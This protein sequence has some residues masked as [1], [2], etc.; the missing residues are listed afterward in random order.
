MHGFNAEVVVRDPDRPVS[1][2]AVLRASAAVDELVEAIVRRWTHQ[3][4]LLHSVFVLCFL[5]RVVGLGIGVFL[6]ALLFLVRGLVLRQVNEVEGRDANIVD[7]L[8][9]GLL[10]NAQVELHVL[11][12]IVR[13][14]AKLISLVFTAAW[15]LILRALIF[16]ARLI[17]VSRLAHYFLKAVSLDKLDPIVFIDL[18]DGN[19]LV[20]QRE[21]EIN[22]LAN[23]VR[24]VCLFFLDLL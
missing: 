13:V 14:E 2:G 11:I 21:E 16:L 18:V 23:L 15:F 1:L 24:V 7:V 5:K 22:E 19:A 9:L 12:A 6:V 3:L 20:L 10:L 4:L 8:E 17:L